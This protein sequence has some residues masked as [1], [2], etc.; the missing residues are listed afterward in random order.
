MSDASFDIASIAHA[1]NA[2]AKSHDIGALQTIRKEIHGFSRRPGSNIF[3]GQTIHPHWAF[4]HGG[5]SELQFNIGLEDNTGKQQLRHGVAFSFELSQALPSIDVLVPKA[6]SFGEYLQLYPDLYADMRM[7][8]YRDGVRGSD[9]PPGPVAPELVRPG[10]FVFLGKRQP[11]DAIEYSMILADF[12]RLLPLYRFVESGGRE[13]SGARPVNSFAFQAGCTEKASATKA[14]LAERELNINLRHTLLQAALCDRLISQYGA[15]N[16]A[17]EHASGLGTKID[18]VLRRTAN[19]FWYYEIKTALSP[20]ACIRE[21]LGQI[22]EYSYWP[23]ASEASRLIICGETA[24]D[25]DGT[26]YL[27]TL[28]QRFGLPVAYEQLDID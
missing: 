20:R 14:S 2:R 27:K 5:R 4:H 3:S 21:A 9:H 19:E 12:D 26:A 15:E 13:L 16:V 8:D 1:I 17:D 24:L 11:T 25:A 28:Q 23:H 6:R 22:M 18:V 10:C 7:W